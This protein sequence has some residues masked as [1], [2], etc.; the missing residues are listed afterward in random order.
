[1]PSGEEEL[2]LSSR[3]TAGSM[4]RIFEASDGQREDAY[5]LDSTG[6]GL[7]LVESVSGG[8]LLRPLVLRLR[9]RR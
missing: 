6:R 2:V 8:R 7:T 1:I 9:Y 5:S 4:L 3:W